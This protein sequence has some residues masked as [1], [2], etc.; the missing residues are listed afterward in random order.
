MMRS[1]LLFLLP[2]S[3]LPPLLCRSEYYWLF[4]RHTLLVNEL[5]VMSN[6]TRIESDYEECFSVCGI[7]DKSVEVHW[8]L[9]AFNQRCPSD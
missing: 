7:V 6:S 5:I 8:V 3:Q 2:L 9:M 4:T 1:V